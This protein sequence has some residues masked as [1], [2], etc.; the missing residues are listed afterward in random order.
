MQV[1]CFENSNSVAASVGIFDNVIDKRIFG[2][3]MVFWL[4]AS[5]GV[6]VQKGQKY[7]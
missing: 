1:Y 5:L 2:G 4:P 6:V 7:R 3:A